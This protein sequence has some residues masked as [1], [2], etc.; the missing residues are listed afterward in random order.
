MIEE[1]RFPSSGSVADAPGSWN[2]SPANSVIV[3]SPSK[4][5]EGLALVSVSDS[6]VVP[7]FDPSFCEDIVSELFVD[8][9]PQP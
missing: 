2:I 3:L 9:P 8:P 6:C 4:V 7:E 5:I 1:V